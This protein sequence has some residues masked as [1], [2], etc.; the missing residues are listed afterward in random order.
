MIRSFPPVLFSPLHFFRSQY[1]PAILEA[2]FHRGLDPSGVD[3]SSWSK[4]QDEACSPLKGTPFLEQ[5]TLRNN[6]VFRRKTGNSS[7]DF[8]LKD[9]LKN[10]LKNVFI[11]YNWVELG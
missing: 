11:W 9:D 1:S 8:F 6:G 7:G 3:L 2:P 4:T 5:I 10:V